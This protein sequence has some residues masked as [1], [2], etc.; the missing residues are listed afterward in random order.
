MVMELLQIKLLDSCGK[1]RDLRK[2]HRGI[3]QRNMWRSWIRRNLQGIMTGEYTASKSFILFVSGLHRRPLCAGTVP[4]LLL[5]QS[6]APL[7]PPPEK[8]A[9]CSPGEGFQMGAN[10]PMTDIW[11]VHIAYAGEYGVTL[12]YWLNTNKGRVCFFGILGTLLNT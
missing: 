5:C 7:F 12:D 6:S 8:T 11:A 4:A 3:L 10:R 9:G 2:K 1:R